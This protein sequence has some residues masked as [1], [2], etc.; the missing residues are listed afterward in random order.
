MRFNNLNTKQLSTFRR[1]G[2]TA[3]IVGASV[4]GLGSTAFAQTSTTSGATT[5]SQARSGNAERGG[6][7][8]ALTTEQQACLTAKGIT[9]KTKP[10][11]GTVRTEK[12]DAQKTADR[13]AFEAAAKACGITLPAAGSGPDG[14]RGRGHDGR[15]PALTAEQQSCLTAKGFTK[16]AAPVETGANDSTTRPTPPTA[17]Q[18]A[19]FEVAAKACGITIP[20]GGRN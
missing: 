16:P 13:T 8:P 15:G 12:T 1:M 20:T 6:G 14:I 3:T 18:R 9:P 7:R 2:L 11:A 17:E 4:L 10:A 5:A 19:A